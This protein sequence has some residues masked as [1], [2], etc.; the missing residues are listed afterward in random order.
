MA[1]PALVQLRAEIAAYVEYSGN[2]WWCL[3]GIFDIRDLKKVLAV[4]EERERSGLSEA[5]AED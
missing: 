2:G 3:D 5:R 1:D 4:M